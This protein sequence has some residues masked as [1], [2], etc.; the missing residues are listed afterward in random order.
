MLKKILS[1]VTE[2][3]WRKHEHEYKSKKVRWA[4]RQFKVILFMF[5]GFGEHSI[6]AR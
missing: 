5:Q 6:M 3:I 4:V 1:F 2:G